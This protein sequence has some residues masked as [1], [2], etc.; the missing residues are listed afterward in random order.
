MWNAGGF[1]LFAGNMP[2]GYF[3]AFWLYSLS[4]RFGH[5]GGSPFIW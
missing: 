2:F 5:I 1:V 3:G 4:P